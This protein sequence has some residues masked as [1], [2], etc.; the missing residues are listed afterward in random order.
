M[1]LKIVNVWKC[2]LASTSCIHMGLSLRLKRL[3]VQVSAR[4]GRDIT[5]GVHRPLSSRTISNSGCSL[6][7]AR[8]APLVP[9]G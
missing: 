9:C 3:G 5:Q 1:S 4:E 7:E 8:G 6:T 2:L